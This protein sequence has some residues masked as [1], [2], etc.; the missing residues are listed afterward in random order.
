MASKKIEEET[1]RLQKEADRNNMLP[2][3]GLHR[4]LRANTNSRNIA[5]K[6]TDGTEWQ[7]MKETMKRWEDW[8]EVCFR[9]NKNQLAPK[10]EPVHDLQ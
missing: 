2:I 4:R 7:G 8:T 6:K 9:R 1:D 10:I 3:W 5:I